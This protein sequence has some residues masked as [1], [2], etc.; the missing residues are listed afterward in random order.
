MTTNNIEAEFWKNKAAALQADLDFAERKL[1]E[2]RK[3]FA[4]E[5]EQDRIIASL[6]AQVAE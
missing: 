5:L 1:A 2:M 4:A 6:A 3:R